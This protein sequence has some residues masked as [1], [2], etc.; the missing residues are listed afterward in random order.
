MLCL[1]IYHTSMIAAADAFCMLFVPHSEHA[2]MPVIDLAAWLLYAS[3]GG[4]QHCG[5]PVS[6]TAPFK[7]VQHLF[8]REIS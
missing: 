5:A 4:E 6:A 7:Y 1:L 8:I 3:P 2:A